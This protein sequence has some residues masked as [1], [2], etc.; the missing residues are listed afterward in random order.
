MKRG[1]VYNHIF[2]EDDWKQVN[3][4]NKNIIQDFIDEYKQRKMKKTTV[5]QYFNDLRIVLIYILHYCENK[6][7]FELNKKDFRRFSLWLT[8]EKNVSNAR[9]NRLMSAVRSLLTYCEDDDDYEYDNNVAKKVHG[10]P[11][12]PIRTNE[13]TFFLSF[14]QIMNVRQYLIEHDRLQDA[15]LWMVFYDS[16]ARRNEV[17]QIKKQGLLDGNKTNEVI[18]KRGK[19]FR[20]VY[21]NDTKEL[22]KQYLEKRGEDNIDSLWITGSGENKKEITYEAIYDRIVSISKILSELDDK[23]INIF[24]HTLRHTRLEHLAQGLDTRL[25]DKETGKPR[26]YSLQEC[27]VYAHHSDPSTTQSYLRD[28][29]EDMIDDMFGI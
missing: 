13:D 24:C 17:Y 11:K 5:D 7:V 12:E 28:H 26:V 1:R 10:L 9:C 19:R 15:V 14:E 3:K 4:E 6:C 25:I 23:E 18:G 22:I 20:L 21:L 29:S 16:A 27:Q 8:E 2:N